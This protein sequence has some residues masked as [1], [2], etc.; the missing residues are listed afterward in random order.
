MK[1]RAPLFVAL[2]LASC[3][4]A[5]GPFRQVSFQAPSQPDPELRPYLQDVARIGVLST[6]NLEPLKELDLEKVMGRLA[7]ATARGL[8]SLRE[9][10]VVTQDEIRWNCKDLRF[11]S[12]GVLTPESR[13]ALREQLA[14]DALVFVDL[15]SLKAQVT[16]MSP[17]P[18]GGMTNQPGLDLS[19][20]LQVALLN[21]RTGQTWTQ[22]GEPRRNWQPTQMQLMGD[23]QA[24]RQ[25][26]QALAGPLQQFISRLAPPPSP[27][28]RHF[29]LGNE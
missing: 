19:V 16:P 7:E 4:T 25:L 5:G 12:T 13:S 23:D 8:G 22:R 10:T 26:L 24:E 11:D 28:V 20:D 27:Q 17:G 9:R 15:K 21:L 1:K 18:Y 6:T 29:D 3:A 2:L 14:L